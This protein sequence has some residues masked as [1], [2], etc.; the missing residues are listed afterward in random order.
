M[1]T[2]AS[3]AE[4]YVFEG[5]LLSGAGRGAGRDVNQSIELVIEVGRGEMRGI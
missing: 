1:R 5:G 4:T 3:R 2:R